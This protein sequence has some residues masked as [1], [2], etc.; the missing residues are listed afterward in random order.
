MWLSPEISSCSMDEFLPWPARMVQGLSSPSQVAVTCTARRHEGPTTY[1][2]RQRQK[3]R[4]QRPRI[5]W[6]CSAFYFF[7]GCAAMLAEPLVPVPTEAPVPAAE[8][9]APSELLLEPLAPSD[10]PLFLV[11][12]APRPRF[13]D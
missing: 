10:V 9:L 12:L 11:E 13:E 4:G 7:R 8:P 5:P 2:A 6:Q 1:K 3:M